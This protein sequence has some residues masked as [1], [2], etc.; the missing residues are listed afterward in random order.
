MTL[1]VISQGQWQNR[2]N[3]IAVPA[4]K[5]TN[6]SEEVSDLNVE[7]V[8]SNVRLFPLRDLNYLSQ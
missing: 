7:N 1:V 3:S 8:Y 4:Y 6:K 5:W 2:L